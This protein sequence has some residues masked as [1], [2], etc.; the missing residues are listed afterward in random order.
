MSEY[1]VI[2]VT[3]ASADKGRGLARTLV[4]E[5]LAACASVVPGVVS[6]F[7]WQGE[8]QEESEVLVVIKSRAALFQAL[9]RRIR[10]LHDYEVPEIL[11]LAVEHGSP[12]YLEWLGN[13]TRAPE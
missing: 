12:P 13:Q 3:A 7:R 4:E 1:L 11:A 9:E 5:R 6:T 8:V 2:L 10:Q